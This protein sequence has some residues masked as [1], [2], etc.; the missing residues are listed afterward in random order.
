MTSKSRDGFAVPA[1]RDQFVAPLPLVAQSYGLQLRQRFLR[2]HGELGF[3]FPAA[4]ANISL[5]SGSLWA[6]WYR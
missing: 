6:A 4:A 1:F 5:A 3:A 2:G